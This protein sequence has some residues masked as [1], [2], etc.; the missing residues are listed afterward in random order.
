M[1]VTMTTETDMATALDQTEKVTTR[2]SALL[3]ARTDAYQQLRTTQ[4]CENPTT[5]QFSITP[6]AIAV[7][8]GLTE[9]AVAGALGHLHRWGVTERHTHALDDGG[10]TYGIGLH[11]GGS[12]ETCAVCGAF[13]GSTPTCDTCKAMRLQQVLR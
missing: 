7:A 6:K 12:T 2:I 5:V 1:E 11:A 4:R 9:D 10:Y 13:P 8:L 3:R